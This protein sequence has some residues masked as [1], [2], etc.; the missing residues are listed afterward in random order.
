MLADWAAERF[1]AEV[2]WF[3]FDLHPEYPPEGKP[4]DPGWRARGEELFAGHGLVYNPPPVAPN[5]RTAL[6]L[7]ELAREQ[8]FHA[9]FH[10]RLMEAYW[11]AAADIGDHDILRRLAVEVGLHAAE[12]EDTLASDRFLDIVLASTRQAQQIGI[13]G[14]PGFLLDERLLVLG[15]Q[16]REVFEQAFA[17]LDG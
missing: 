5:T 16:P 2:T 3:P 14:I 15:A 10:D 13:S 4:R 1:G 11:T 9:A 8:G 7:T 17:Q 6:R 12:V